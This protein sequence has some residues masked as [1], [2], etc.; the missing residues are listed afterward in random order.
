MPYKAILPV[1]ILGEFRQEN[2][3]EYV[4]SDSRWTKKAISLSSSD[5][6]DKATSNNI[7]RKEGG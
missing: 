6:K 2:Q 1:F 3:V 5:P 7:K 4:W